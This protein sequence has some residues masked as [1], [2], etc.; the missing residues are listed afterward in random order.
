MS[1]ATHCF[2]V[3]VSSY[4]YIYLI[5]HDYIKFNFQFECCKAVCCCALMHK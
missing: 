1:Y 5:I 3:L 4:L 2:V